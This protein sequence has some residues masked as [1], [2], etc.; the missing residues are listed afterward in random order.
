V[1]ALLNNAL[2]WLLEAQNADGGWGGDR[3]VLS[4]IEE[5][6]LAVGALASAAVAADKL[7]SMR[8]ALQRG[9]HWLDAATDGVDDLPAAPIGLY[10]ARLWYSESLYPALFALDGLGRAARALAPAP[11]LTFSGPQ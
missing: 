5:T 6:G 8:P 2:R 7:E 4:S 10:F 3:G 9:C 11:A 1:D